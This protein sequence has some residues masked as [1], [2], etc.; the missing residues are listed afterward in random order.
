MIRFFFRFLECMKEFVQ[1][2]LGIPPTHMTDTLALVSAYLKAKYLRPTRRPYQVS[3]Q[4]ILFF[5]FADFY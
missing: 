2:N 5:F 4:F 3:L 1:E